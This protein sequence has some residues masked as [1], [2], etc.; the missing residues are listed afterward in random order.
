MIFTAYLDESNTG[1]KE[2]DI[3]VAGYLGSAPQWR[4][5]GRR[6]R[7]LKR[8][9]GFSSFHAT[10]F[11]AKQDDFRGWSDAKCGRLVQTLATLE[12]DELE[13][14]V[15]IC[16]PFKQ[17]VSSYRDAPFE[18]GVPT[19]SQ[20]G[21]CLYLMLDALV[22]FVRKRSGVHRLHLVVEAGHRNA[23]AARTVFAAMKDHLADG[24]SLLGTVTVATKEDCELLMMADFQAHASGISDNWERAGHP[25]YIRMAGTRS[26]AKGEAAINF[27]HPNSLAL[28]RIKDR[29]IQRREAKKAVYF[30]QKGTRHKQHALISARG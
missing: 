29:F 7:Q 14:A 9:F 10:R 25:G 6:L 23:G 21:V 13:E 8:E 12:R 15:T 2:P 24:S 4:I 3:T 19:F 16:L 22:Y 26:P 5:V 18:K 30:K 11:K 27:I 20:Y 28:Q 17:Y 1:A